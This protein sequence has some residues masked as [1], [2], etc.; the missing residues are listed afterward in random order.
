MRMMHI[1]IKLKPLEWF[2]EN[3][4][5]DHEGDY[6]YTEES[7]DYFDKYHNTSQD[8]GFSLYHKTIEVGYIDIRNN[9]KEIEKYEWMIERVLNEIDDSMYFV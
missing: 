7:R 8:F 6:W 9:E 1:K 2:K 5:I 4:F 3:A